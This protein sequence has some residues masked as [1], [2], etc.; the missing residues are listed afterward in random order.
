M[1]IVIH[2]KYTTQILYNKIVFI[3]KTVSF[4]QSNTADKVIRQFVR[5]LRT[6]A[7]FINQYRY[8]VANAQTSINQ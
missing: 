7:L 5:K 8:Y 6:T 4:A 2:K 1:L 3:S